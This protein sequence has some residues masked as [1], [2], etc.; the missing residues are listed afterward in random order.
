MNYEYPN[1]WHRNCIYKG[2]T[3]E[4]KNKMTD[5]ELKARRFGRM[6]ALN[7]KLNKVGDLQLVRE[8]WLAF[9]IDSPCCDYGKLREWHWNEF[10][11]WIE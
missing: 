7:M 4:R 5:Q 3:N 1:G 10:Y 2:M 11:F 8:Q 6:E 9:L